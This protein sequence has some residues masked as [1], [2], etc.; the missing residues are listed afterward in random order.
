MRAR[1]RK[2]LQRF[3]AAVEFFRT[4]ADILAKAPPS[5][6]S[7]LQDLRD[8]VEIIEAQS[9]SQ[10]SGVQAQTAEYRWAMREIL[11]VKHLAPLRQVLR[12]ASRTQAGVYKLAQV[13]QRKA[14]VQSLLQVARSTVNDVADYQATIVRLGFPEDFLDQLRQAID[15]VAQA[16][17]A[18]ALAWQGRKQ[19]AG[20]VAYSMQVAYDALRC[21]DIAVRRVCDE[22]GNAGSGPLNAWNGIVSPVRAGEQKVNPYVASDGVGENGVG[23]DDGSVTEPAVE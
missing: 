7:H 13:P 14:S 8:A 22:A 4:H 3:K 21:L 16:H 23:G 11:R 5:C 10:T 6:G 19:A 18:N 12:V 17:E 9:A 1:D 2:R 20:M 15:R